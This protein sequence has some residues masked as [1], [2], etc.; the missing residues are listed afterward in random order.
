MVLREST[1]SVYMLEP[2]TEKIHLSAPEAI[3]CTVNTLAIFPMLCLSRI[4]TNIWL[5]NDKQSIERLQ[6]VFACDMAAW[7]LCNIQNIY[8]Y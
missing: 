2:L 8:H 3:L 1:P 6:K 4:R 7:Q 5:G